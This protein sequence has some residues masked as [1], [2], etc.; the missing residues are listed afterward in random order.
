MLKSVARVDNLCVPCLY[1][2]VYA[3]AHAYYFNTL[4]FYS[5]LIFGMKMS[6][7]VPASREVVVGVVADVAVVVLVERWEEARD[8]SMQR[9]GSDVCDE[10]DAGWDVRAGDATLGPEMGRG[11]ARVGA[12]PGGADRDILETVSETRRRALDAGK[13]VAGDC[14]D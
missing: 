8:A 9:E 13:V 10:A 6:I 4:L 3:Y 11:G 7:G 5:V 1:A 14:G 12:K 2:H